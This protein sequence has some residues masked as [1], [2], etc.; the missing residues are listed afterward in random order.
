MNHP[1]STARF[2]D[3]T[4]FTLIELLVVITIIGVLAGLLL[5]VVQKVQESAKKVSAKNTETQIV[6]AISTY[7][8]DYGQ[9]PV[10]VAANA[11]TTDLTFGLDKIN[12]NHVVLDV[13]RAIN[14][15]DANGVLLNSRR[16]PYFESKNVKNVGSAR[17]GFIPPGLTATGNPK[18]KTPVQLVGGDLV[19]PWGNMYI[20]RVDSNYTNVLL[21]PYA[22][23]APSN[24]E[25]D[26]AT[27]PPSASA[28]N[29]I[30][31]GAICWTYGIDGMIGDKGATVTAPYS[32]APGDD[33]DSWQ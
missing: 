18:L 3:R 15:K 13:L 8:T 4:A 5:P 27:S 14:D 26:D 21:N 25:S 10:S 33:V 20:I 22:S 28:T 11:A 9:Y 2:S 29:V 30:R 31:T 16:I 17:D 7:Q 24:T 12:P 19:D 23:G 1:H 32:P 6:S